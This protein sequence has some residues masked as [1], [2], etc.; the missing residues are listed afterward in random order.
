[1]TAIELLLQEPAARAIG[2]ALLHF[3]W[4]GTVVGLIAAVALALLRRNDADV[5]YVV[6]T[7]ALAVMATLPLV[8]AFQAYDDARQRA[9]VVFSESAPIGAPDPTTQTTVAQTALVLPDAP[10]QSSSPRLRGES[11]EPWIPILVLAWMIGVG[12]LTL[13]LFSGWLWVQRMKSHGARL[14]GP[15]LQASAAR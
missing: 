5:R 15:A 4:Q 12:V 6:A 11:V 3:I 8:T 10:I 13:R 2:W 9:T 14:A 1:M 7:I